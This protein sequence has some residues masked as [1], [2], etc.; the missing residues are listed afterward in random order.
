LYKITFLCILII[1]TFIIINIHKIR[2]KDP[3]NNLIIN[4]YNLSDDIEYILQLYQQ[5]NIAIPLDI[6]EELDHQ[7]SN[8]NTSQ[9]IISFIEGQRYNWKLENQKKFK[10]PN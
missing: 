6:I 10:P 7:Q 5:L 8:L 9:D 2:N 4:D 3:T 1:L